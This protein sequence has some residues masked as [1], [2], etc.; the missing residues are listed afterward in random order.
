M[1][2]CVKYV[3]K[4]NDKN[5]SLMRIVYLLILQS[6]VF[7][8]AIQRTVLCTM[9]VFVGARWKRVGLCTRMSVC[10]GA[11]AQHVIVIV[12]KIECKVINWEQFFFIY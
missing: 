8:D 12:T 10:A 3:T 6:F 9:H 11:S 7:V 2:V 5:Q 4:N 1:C